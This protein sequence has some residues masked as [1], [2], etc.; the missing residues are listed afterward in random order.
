M[1]DLSTNIS[2]SLLNANGIN[3]P[4]DRDQ[5]SNFKNMT[6]ICCLQETHFK[7]NSGG[8]AKVK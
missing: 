7:C 2:I 8:G 3:I 4:I 1:A 6:T 5:Q